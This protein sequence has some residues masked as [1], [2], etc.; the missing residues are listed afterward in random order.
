MNKHSPIDYQK[1]PIGNRLSAIGYCQSRT[2]APASGPVRR[3]SGNIQHRTS[4]IEHPIL[5]GPGR[6]PA[7]LL[8]GTLL[9]L[10][11]CVS[12]KTSPTVD[13][14]K[15]KLIPAEDSRFRYQGRIDF[16]DR[17]ALVLIWQASAVRLDFNGDTATLLFDHP[18]GQC[19]FNA[20]VDGTTTIVEVC[21]GKPVRGTNL[22]GLGPGRHHLTLFKR[23][24][25]SAGTVHFRGIELAPT[26]R[27]WTPPTPAYKTR[28]EFI[29]DSITA[30]AC[31]E[32]AEKDQWED[33][34]TH[35]SALSYAALTADAFSA[36]Y[37]NIAVSGMGIATGWTTVKAWEIWD[38]LY[39][40]P[41][42]ARANLAAWTPKVVFVNLGENDDSFSRAH[43]QPF[44]SGYTDGYVALVQSIRKSYPAARIVLLRGGMNGGGQ[45]EPLRIAWEAA[46]VRLEAADPNISHFV[47]KHWTSDHPRVKDHRAMAEELIGWVREQRFTSDRR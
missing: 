20:T 24:E 45:S 7:L 33:R 36:D 14:S 35:N 18:T 41:S 28:F 32:D 16:S 40:D 6:R 26:A 4:N 23:S 29:G 3:W 8:L 38:R 19:F 12:C 31:N 42:S 21:E 47:F 22:S 1:S 30:G 43:G 46:V 27:A 17:T 34:R 15:T 37:R 11:L 9:T 13:P 44:P 39:P 2:G 25:A 5:S 10:T